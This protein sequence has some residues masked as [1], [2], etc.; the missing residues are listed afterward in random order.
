[1]RK[2]PLFLKKYFWDIDFNRLNVAEKSIYVIERILELG[3]EKAIKWLFR[4]FQKTLIKKVIIGSRGLS[5]QTA[6]FW[7]LILDIDQ[8]EIR[9]LQK[10]FLRLRQTH[11]PY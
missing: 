6:S 8:K 1:M 11:W 2:A 9:C 10:P 4:K 3:D 7:S 5:P